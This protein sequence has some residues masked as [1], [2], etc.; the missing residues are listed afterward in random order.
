MI[1]IYPSVHTVTVSTAEKSGDRSMGESIIYDYVTVKYDKPHKYHIGNINSAMIIW[2]PGA[3]GMLA[4]A[5]I[6]KGGI[7][8]SG[9]LID[10]VAYDL[11]S[12]P[13]YENFGNFTYEDDFKNTYV[14]Y[15]EGIYV[16][17]QYYETFAPDKVLYSLG[18]G[19]SYSDFD[20]GYNR[21]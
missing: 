15:E 16:G 19:L 17:Y 10:A 8:P 11:S 3:E 7:N 18:Y 20:W 4:V 6:L 2:S 13:A 9:R 21:F 5:D 14:A 12:N 1:G